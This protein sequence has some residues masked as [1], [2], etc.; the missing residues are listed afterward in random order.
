MGKKVQSCKIQLTLPQLNGT[1]RC[2]DS[3]GHNISSSV[4][5]LSFCA[6]IDVINL[7]YTTAASDL[8]GSLLSLHV[9]NKLKCGVCSSQNIHQQINVVTRDHIQ[10]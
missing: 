8:Q 7:Q 3:E 9:Q 4:S 10:A 2:Y 1:R 6:F 5:L